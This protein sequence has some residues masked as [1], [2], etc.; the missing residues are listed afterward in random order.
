MWRA[1]CAE[2]DVNVNTPYQNWY[3]SNS[4]ETAAELAELVLSGK[5]RATASSAAMNEIEP[6][7]APIPDGYSVVTD[8]DGHPMGVIRTTEIRHLPFNEVD[9]DFAFD[10]G[11]GDQSLEYWREAHWSYFTKEAA[12]H[13]FYFDENSVVCCERFELV[14]PAEA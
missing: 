13:G 3:F 7:K 12:Q 4:P 6:D 11:E 14:Y 8:F 10:E 1:F 9:A 5:K 2:T